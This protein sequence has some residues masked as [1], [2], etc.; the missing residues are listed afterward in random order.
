VFRL[1]QLSEPL[2]I[3][4]SHDWPSGVWDYGNKEQLIRFKPFFEYVV[5]ILLNQFNNILL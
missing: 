4:L 5:E 3:F 2:N 1:K